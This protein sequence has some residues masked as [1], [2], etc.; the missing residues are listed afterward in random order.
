MIQIR[1][2]QFSFK[3][4]K[5]CKSSSYVKFY[6]IKKK[7]YYLVLSLTRIKHVTTISRQRLQKDKLYIT[8]NGKKTQKEEVCS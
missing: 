4:S 7:S 8:L 6:M 1:D 5:L 3:I 2:L